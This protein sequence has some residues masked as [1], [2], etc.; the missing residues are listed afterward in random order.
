M[1]VQA[2][3]SPQFDIERVARSLDQL[4]EDIRPGLVA[5]AENAAPYLLELGNWLNRTAEAIA[6]HLPA[7]AQIAQNIL[8]QNAR[9]GTVYLGAPQPSIRDGLDRRFGPV[10]EPQPLIPETP[11]YGRDGEVRKFGF[12]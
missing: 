10:P 5:A 8:D 12:L 9:M 7:A 1:S 2:E 4:V 6:P 11:L 3:Q